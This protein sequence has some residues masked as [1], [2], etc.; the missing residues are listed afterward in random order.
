MNF[1]RQMSLAVR[2]VANRIIACFHQRQFTSEQVVIFHTLTCQ[3]IASREHGVANARQ[4][5]RHGKMTRNTESADL[6]REFAWLVA[7][8]DIGRH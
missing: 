4:L 3:K 6:S 7:I 5:A 2:R 1:N 8:T